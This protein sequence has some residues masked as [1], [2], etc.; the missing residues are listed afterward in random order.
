MEVS[1]LFVFWYGLLHAFGP[2]HLTAIADFSIGRQRKKVMLVTLGFALGHGLSLYLFSL[3]LA[4]VPGIEGWLVYGDIVAASIIMLMGLYLLFLSFSN[5]IHVAKHYHAGKE[6]IHI[7]FGKHH[8]HP[9][10]PK[11]LSWLSAS[12]MI[13]IMMGVGGVRG[14]L[15]TLSAISHQAV[16]G[17]MILSFTLGVALVFIAFG[18]VISVLNERLLN[19]KAW[20]RGGFIAVGFMSCFVGVQGLMQ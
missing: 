17:W 15:I 1:I 16:S 13:G 12:T 19:S 11:F 14:M 4:S 10:E 2:D 5:R 9:Q 18:V 20:L 3:V 7:W 6:H 8:N